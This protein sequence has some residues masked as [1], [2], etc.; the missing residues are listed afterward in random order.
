MFFKKKASDNSRDL[1]KKATSIFGADVITATLQKFNTES[2]LPIVSA[3]AP[4]AECDYVVKG[5][6]HSL[7]F[8]LYFP[9]KVFNTERDYKFSHWSFL[10]CCITLLDNR[11]HILATYALTGKPFRNP[12]NNLWVQNGKYKGLSVW[13]EGQSLSPADHHIVEDLIGWTDGE[14]AALWSAQYAL[15]IRNGIA[16]IAFW[17]PDLY[18]YE[19][20]LK[21]FAEALARFYVQL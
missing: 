14:F 9:V 12:D 19:S 7:R 21:I 18:D 16:A 20:Q 4:N 2:S 10:G 17:E 13:S 1:L 3:F 11:Y 5:G 8:G 6:Y 15:L